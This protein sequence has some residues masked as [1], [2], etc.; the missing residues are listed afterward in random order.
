[1]D[2]ISKL[3]LGLYILIIII[4]TVA[5]IIGQYRKRNIS[6]ILTVILYIILI[7]QLYIIYKTRDW[8]NSERSL[9]YLSF[10]LPTVL[11]TYYVLNNT[12]F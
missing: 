5:I 7:A 2:K 6:W 12:L 11:I 9:I 3:A 10:L 4:I 8:D 1:M